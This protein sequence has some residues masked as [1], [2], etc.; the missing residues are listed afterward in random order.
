MEANVPA[1]VANISSLVH[2]LDVPSIYILSTNC[3]HDF[4]TEA[5]I[6]A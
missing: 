6:T 5:C 3:S 4:R 1:N 2:S